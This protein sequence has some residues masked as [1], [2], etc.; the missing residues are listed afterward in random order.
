VTTTALMIAFIFIVLI[1]FYSN[2][3]FDLNR[4]EEFL[5]SHPPSFV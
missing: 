2:F 3:F 5:N 4:R 1:P